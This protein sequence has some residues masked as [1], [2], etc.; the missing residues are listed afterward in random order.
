MS[1]V[2]VENVGKA[3]FSFSLDGVIVGLKNTNIKFCALGYSCNGKVR[4][5][6]SF[7]LISALRFSEKG[8]D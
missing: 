5:G 4:A 3:V 8:S 6:P 1:S 2:D 7:C